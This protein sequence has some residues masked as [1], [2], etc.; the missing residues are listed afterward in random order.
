[1]CVKSS[2]E[3]VMLEVAVSAM[4]S[5]YFQVSRGT[6]G[7]GVFCSTLLEFLSKSTNRPL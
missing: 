1:M 2:Y 7:G 5:H 4:W 3:F 6:A